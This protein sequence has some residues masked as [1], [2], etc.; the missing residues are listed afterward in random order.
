MRVVSFTEPAAFAQRV[1]PLLMRRE[2]ENNFILGKISEFES[3]HGLPPDPLLLS[4]QEVH[5]DP[6]PVG[7]ALMMPPNPLVMTRA[8]A[9]AVEALVQHLSRAGVRPRAVSGPEPA[10]ATFAEAWSAATGIP[11]R[12]EFRMGLYQ[13]T[14]LAPPARP[15]PGSFRA[16]GEADVDFLVPWAEAFFREIRHFT[17]PQASKVV[18]ERVRRGQLYLWCDP[19][20]RPVSMAGWAGPTPNGVRVNAVF[21]P[22]EHRG[23]GYAT[24]CVASLT[25]HLLDSGRKF[26]FLFTDL[27]N[28]TS[29]RI[30]QRLG[31]EHVCDMRDVRFE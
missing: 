11:H 26:C 9:A 31:Y 29:N 22:P 1:T 24:A 28:P 2:A 20:G 6:H 27:A 21:T 8:P 14:R 16:A 5:E 15:V 12:S 4:L 17:A 7:A 18:P 13:L 30:Y 3:G 23:R 10:S 25:R 19:P